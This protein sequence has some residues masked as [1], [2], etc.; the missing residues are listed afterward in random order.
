MIIIAAF[1]CSNPSDTKSITLNVITYV[2]SEYIA[3]SNPKIN[4]ATP[5]IIKLKNN[6]TCPTLNDVF[7]LITIAT[8]SV[9][10]TQPPK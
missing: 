7:L 5:N 6:T 10:S 1:A 4:P 2:S 9:P 3:L 8:L